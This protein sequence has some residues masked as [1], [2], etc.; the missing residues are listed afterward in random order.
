[1]NRFLKTALFLI[2]VACVIAVAPRLSAREQDTTKTVYFTALDKS[3]KPLTDFTAD[4]VAVFED[5]KMRPTVSVKKAT[6]P[7]SI[8]LLADTTKTVSGSGIDRRSTSGAAAGELI[9]DIRDAFSAFVAQ[10][11]TADPKTEMALMEFGQAAIMVTDFSTKSDDLTKGIGH[12][13]A[14]PNANSVLLEAIMEG[15]KELEKRP[16]PRRALVSINVEP[17]DEDSKEP[18]NNIM[19]QLSNARAPLFSVSL[20]KGDLRNPSRGPVLDGLTDKT[21]GRHDAL[22]GQSALV[23][24]LKQYADLLNAQMEISFM[25][26]AGAPPQVIQMA[27]PRKDIK[28][29]QSKF[30]PK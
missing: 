8:V 22:V 26:P 18:A 10:M 25:R 14:K 27:T 13:V 1:M 19:K 2:P 5:G 3:G 16:S 15:S 7:L 20:Q 24:M 21:G 12:L 28:F 29:L 9:R 11:S 4:D 6:T 23:G 30:P 17:S